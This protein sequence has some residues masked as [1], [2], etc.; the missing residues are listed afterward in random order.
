MDGK[1]GAFACFWS[2]RSDQS[3]SVVQEGALVAVDEWKARCA[4]PCNWKDRF[5]GTSD[6]GMQCMEG[7]DSWSVHTR[8]EQP[9]NEFGK[10]DL[11]LDAW[12]VRGV[13]LG[14]WKE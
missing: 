3:T 2:G 1:A 9:A 8:K 10:G 6:P 11:V 7:A 5:W 14:S 12:K 13:G 4:G